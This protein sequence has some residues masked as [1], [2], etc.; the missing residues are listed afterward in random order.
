[1]TPP[2][3]GHERRLLNLQRGKTPRLSDMATSVLMW[4]RP[5]SLAVTLASV[6]LISSIA[7]L[8]LTCSPPVTPELPLNAV[9]VYG[10]SRS[11]ALVHRAIVRSILKTQPTAV[12]HTGDLV[13]DGSSSADWATFNSITSELTES[14]PFYPALGNH[15]LPPQL[16]FDNFSLPNNERWYSVDVDGLHFIVLDSNS[17]ITPGSEQYRW[18]ETDLQAAVND[19]V[20]VVFHQPLMSTGRH[21]GDAVL[22]EIVTPL[23]EEYSVELV[24]NG[25]DHDYERSSTDGIYYVV[26]GGGGAPLRNQ[27][28]ASPYSQVFDSAYHFCT[29]S[30]GD[31]CVTVRAFDLDLHLIDQFAIEE[32]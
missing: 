5:R 15:D 24:I 18:L 23:F 32:A 16:F 19:F 25:H 9:A 14:T 6:L 21:G 30:T 13:N 22:R 11:G 7:S 10:D 3:E 2:V 20:S 27:E 28:T 31:G 12:F 17:D 26:T 8:G 4:K 1:V 29:L